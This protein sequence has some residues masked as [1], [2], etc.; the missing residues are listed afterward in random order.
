MDIDS[1]ASLDY[2]DYGAIN[3]FKGVEVEELS[4]CPLHEWDIEAC[5][6][7]TTYN[8]N[9]DSIRPCETRDIMNRAIKVLGEGYF[10]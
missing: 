7:G 2:C 6:E 8:E 3:P 10:A 4:P 1:G 5:V 9:G